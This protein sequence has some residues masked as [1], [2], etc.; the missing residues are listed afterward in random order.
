MRQRIRCT[1]WLALCGI[2]PAQVR[3]SEGV[4][5]RVRLEEDLSSATAREG[6]SI[7][8]TVAEDTKVG[9]VVAIAQGAEVIGRI[10]TAVPRKLGS[11]KLDF[12]IEQVTAVDGSTISLRYGEDKN[13]A[14]KNS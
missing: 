4:A 2:A 14:G 8:L 9:E 11:G 1:V 5:V 3:I 12:S 7:R 13:N 6:Q 10:T